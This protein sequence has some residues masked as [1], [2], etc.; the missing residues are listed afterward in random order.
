VKEG[1]LVD[2][3][4]LIIRELAMERNE[5]SKAQLIFIDAVAMLSRHS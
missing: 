3:G 1:L 5:M 4:K 2:N